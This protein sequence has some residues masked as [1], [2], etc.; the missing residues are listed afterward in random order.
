MA[1]EVD[2]AQD[3]AGPLLE[4]EVN[5]IRQRVANMPVGVPGECDLR[6]GFSQRLVKGVC[7]SCPDR[8]KL[9]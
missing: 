2:H 3:L 7:A 6:G 1:D 5:V 4:A 9:P 8:H